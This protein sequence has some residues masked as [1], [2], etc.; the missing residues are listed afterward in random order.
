MK[1]RFEESF[2]SD[3]EEYA[4][5]I[6]FFDWIIR[7]SDF[8]EILSTLAKDTGFGSEVLGCN[9][10]SLFEN[11]EEDGYF[12]DGI[13]F[14]LNDDDIK[15]DFSMYVK[16][17]ELACKIYIEENGEEEEIKNYFLSIKKRYKEM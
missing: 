10:P 3:K 17:L 14:Y 16:C 8:K 12:D 13:E 4:I 5:V 15:I 6:V 1:G 7:R 11:K 2:F 9:L